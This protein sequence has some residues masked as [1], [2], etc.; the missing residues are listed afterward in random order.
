MSVI[1]SVKNLPDTLQRIV[2]LPA[3]QQLLFRRSDLS[4]I[5][6]GT[7]PDKL[8]F[9]HPELHSSA[10][11]QLI[12][13]HNNVLPHHHS[14]T[15]VDLKAQLPLKQ[16][17]KSND[18]AQRISAPS[19]SEEE[20]AIMRGIPIEPLHTHGQ[21]RRVERNLSRRNFC[22][23]L[24]DDGDGKQVWCTACSLAGVSPHHANRSAAR[25]SLFARSLARAPLRSQRR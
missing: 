7:I 24:P 21:F 15:D 19:L 4:A 2:Q 1:V 3:D 10:A 22:T 5:E 6:N 25:T 16:L 13:D 11:A 23:V 8:S 12:I 17:K 14:R 20:I 9:G 18:E